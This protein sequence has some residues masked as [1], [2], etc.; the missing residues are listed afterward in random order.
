MKTTALTPALVILIA[1]T[2]SKNAFAQDAPPVR[3]KS[4]AAQQETPPEQEGGDVRPLIPT[5]RFIWHIPDPETDRDFALERMERARRE[6]DRTSEVYIQRVMGRVEQIRREKQ[7]PLTLEEAIIRAL[8]TNFAIQVAAYNPAVETTRVVEAEAA[9][10]AVFFTSITKNNVDRPTGSQLI[11]TDLDLFSS[12]YGVRKL[13]PSGAQVGASYGLNRSS[14]S[15]AFQQINPEYT[16]NFLLDARQPLLRGFGIDFNR[17]LIMVAKNDRR[18]SDYLFSRQVRETVRAV[19]ELYWRL[20]QARRDIVITA[21]LLGDFEA[22]YEYL[23][24]RQEFDITPVQIAATKANL[25]EART[26]FILRR[27]TVFDAEDR[28][29]AIMNSDDIDLADDIEIIPTSLPRLEPVVL[30]RLSEVQ[31]ALDHR[32]EIREQELRVESAKI[33]VGRQRNLE[34]PRMDLT[35]R[36][37]YHGL[38]VSADASFDQLT[39]GNFIEYFIGVEFEYP[40]GNRSA[41]ASSRRAQLQFDQQAAELRRVIEEVVLDTNLAVRSVTTAYEAIAPSFLSTEAREREVDSIVAR[42]ERKDFV[43][44][45]QELGARQSLADSRR[46]LLLAMVQY[47]VAMIELER[48]KGTL[49]KYRNVYIPTLEESRTIQRPFTPEP[50]ATD[51]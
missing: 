25:E 37:T 48:S 47:N 4:D 23:Q 12:S 46:R 36:S 30:D 26:D 35:F 5:E 24:A 33:L 14:S 15:L 44:L 8:A 22:I 6:A 2:L 10:D 43:V 38:G 9:F 16:S 18:S 32:Q 13:L 42:A 1:A 17:S 31:A 41:R 49:L 27:A 19:E 39:E 20:V 7:R 50:A 11:S 29:T 45:N 51:N 40:I 21:R 34:L 28:L 3:D